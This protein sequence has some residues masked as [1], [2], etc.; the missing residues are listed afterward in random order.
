MKTFK[1]GNAEVVIHR[2]VT[3]YRNRDQF[4]EA[5]ISIKGDVQN[6]YLRNEI[7]D[8]TAN[9]IGQI[10]FKNEPKNRQVVGH[11]P[12]KGNKAYELKWNIRIQENYMTGGQAL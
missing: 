9:A 2:T 10:L 8:L 11:G 3:Y 6:F 1:F 5:L 4:T 7:I 12:I